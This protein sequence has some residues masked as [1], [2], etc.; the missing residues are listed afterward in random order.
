MLPA[1]CIIPRKP[2]F[3]YIASLGGAG[4]IRT[5][6]QAASISS[7]RIR[8]REVFD[9]WPISLAG[10]MMVIVPS[11]D[12]VT[13]GLRVADVAALAL[14]PIARFEM[15]TELVATPKL[16]PAALIMTPRRLTTCKW[17]RDFSMVIC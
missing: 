1:V 10:D 4:T 11:A 6:S 12:I 5:F 14:E 2:G 3:P 17:R 15:E 13:H 8:G 7:A 16:R 9:P